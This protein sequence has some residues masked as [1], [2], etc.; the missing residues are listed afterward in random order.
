[1]RMRRASF[2]AAFVAAFVAGCSGD[3]ASKGNVQVFVVAEESITSGVEPGTGDEN[4]QDGWRV[5]YSKFLVT[6]GNF[7]AR[8]TESGKELRDPTVWVLDLKSAPAAG[9]S[10]A[11]F[12]D[13]DAVRFD[14]AGEDM[15]VATAAAKAAPPTTEADRQLMIGGGY[16]L[17]VE[18]KMTKADGQSCTPGK[19]TE[20]VAAKEIKF[21]WGFA[22]GTAFDDCASA[23]GDTGFAVPKGG[24]VQIKPTIHGD[25]W[26]FSDI[27]EGA[28]I[29]R[30]Y[31]QYIADADVNHDGT[32]TIDELK[33]VRA[34]DAFPIDKYKLSGGVDGPIATAWDFVRSQA[35]TVHDFQGDGECPTRTVLK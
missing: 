10:I 1:M 27:T 30:R 14:K 3:D 34:A 24:E 5:E 33:S 25:H 9:Y 26:F 20:C 32:T 12:T 18:G 29:T 19:P 15:P 2:V 11:R 22:M 23:Q 16:S 17:Y 8:S 21:A 28:E 35:R 4:M 7:R 31:A 13:I 6:I